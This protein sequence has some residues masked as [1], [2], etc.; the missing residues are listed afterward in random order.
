MIAPRICYVASGSEDAW[1]GPTAEKEAWNRAHDLWQ[2]YGCPE[3]MGYHCHPGPHR[4]SAEDWAH[5]LDFA[6]KV[7]NKGK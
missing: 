3:K 5:F 1:A 4:I 6:D 2:A 7:W